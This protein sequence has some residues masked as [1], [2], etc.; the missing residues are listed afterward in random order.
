ME[1]KYYA[2]VILA[3]FQDFPMWY[4]TSFDYY[5]YLMGSFYWTW[6]VV[7]IDCF[8]NVFVTWSCLPLFRHYY[9]FLTITIKIY[10]NDINN[11]NITVNGVYTNIY[12]G[13]S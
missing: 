12:V 5:Y 10:I 4:F 11:A 3:L 13:L 7:K 1:I 8:Y 9:I 2:L 6:Q